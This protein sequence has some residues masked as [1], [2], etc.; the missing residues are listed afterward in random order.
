MTYEELRTAMEA[1]GKLIPKAG[2]GPARC[3][4]EGLRPSAAATCQHLHWMIEEALTFPPEKY[5]KLDRW[6]GF[7][8]GAAWTL[9]LISIE[10]LRQINL[11]VAAPEPECTCYE[12]MP[13]H[14]PGCPMRR[15]P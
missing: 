3:D 1:T 10:Q 14:E 2:E 12:A 7:V 8:Q 13:G 4:I 15:R 9:H 11:G 5:L 6:L